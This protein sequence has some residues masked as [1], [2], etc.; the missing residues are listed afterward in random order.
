MLLLSEANQV[1]VKG[2]LIVTGDFK[3]L[4]TELHKAEFWARG[5][6]EGNLLK[7]IKKGVFTQMNYSYEG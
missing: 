6:D 1:T 4:K 2:S 7:A 5:V 3:T